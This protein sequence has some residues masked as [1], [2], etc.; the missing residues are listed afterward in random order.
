MYR[1]GEFEGLKSLHTID[2]DDEPYQFYILGVWG[3]EDGL[4]IATDSGC[5]CPAYWES[6]SRDDLTGPLT[7]E[8]AFEECNELYKHAG[9]RDDGPLE[10]LLTAMVK[11]VVSNRDTTI[12]YETPYDVPYPYEIRGTLTVIDADGVEHT[13]TGYDDKWDGNTVALTDLKYPLTVVL[14]GA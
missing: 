11:W 6:T 9:L 2:L 13:R 5:S 8:Q 10:D 7:I 12:R 14:G 4:Y 1:Y 3:G